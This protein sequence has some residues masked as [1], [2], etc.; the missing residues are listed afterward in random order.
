M[1]HMAHCMCERPWRWGH[2]PM[3]RGCR[4]FLKQCCIVHA[5]WDSTRTLAAVVE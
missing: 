4:Q 3:T 5:C 1:L 2:V